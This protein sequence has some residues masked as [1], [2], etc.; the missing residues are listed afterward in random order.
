[1]NIHHVVALY[2]SRP[3]SLSIRQS[4]PSSS[5][6]FSSDPSSNLLAPVFPLPCLLRLACSH[7]RAP[8]LKYLLGWPK[9]DV[10]PRLLGW[11]AS[12]RLKAQGSK[13]ESSRLDRPLESSMSLTTCQSLFHTTPTLHVLCYSSFTRLL[14]SQHFASLRRWAKIQND[15]EREDGRVKLRQR[16]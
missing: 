1:M 15:N 6:S 14:H 8:S 7:F 10:G 9:F 12:S 2:F 13:L 5:S 3:F 11:L 4:S 16:G